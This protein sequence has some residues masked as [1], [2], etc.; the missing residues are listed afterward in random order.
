MAYL[1]GLLHSFGYL[2]LAEVF[3]P[4]FSQY[5]RLAEANPHVMP[6]TIERHLLGV[7]RDQLAGT[8]MRSEEHTSELQ[9]RGHLVCRL[10]LEKKNDY[11]S[12]ICR[13]E[14][15]IQE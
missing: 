2:I 3:P 6:Q 10:L 8:L 15:Y 12:S 5:C 11:R 14:Q 13:Q 4:Y 1:G 7:T 9:S